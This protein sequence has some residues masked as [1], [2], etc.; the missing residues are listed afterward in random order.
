MH[1][2]P[3]L[4]IN[5]YKILFL[6]LAN[7]VWYSKISIFW[8]ILIFE[9]AIITVKKHFLWRV[10]SRFTHT[11][12]ILS[13]SKYLSNPYNIEIALRARNSALSFPVSPRFSRSIDK[14]KLS[15]THSLPF[16]LEVIY[17]HMIVIDYSAW[18][19]KWVEPLST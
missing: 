10:R 18:D 9:N 12:T 6:L 17:Y 14:K 4:I 16:S 2:T 3:Y 13:S 1:E 15:H 11:H 8:A 5:C 7:L 19:R